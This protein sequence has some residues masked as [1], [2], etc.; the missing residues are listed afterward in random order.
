MEINNPSEL[1]NNYSEFK[2]DLENLKENENKK[3]YL[4]HKKDLDE[5]F[6]I[7]KNYENKSMNDLKKELSNKKIK[8][9]SK[10]SEIEDTELELVDKKFVTFLNDN[11][12]FLKN[13]ELILFKR[14]KEVQE[15]I[16]RHNKILKIKNKTILQFTESP[17]DLDN[18]IN[19]IKRS[20]KN[21]NKESE[22]LKNKQIN[23]NFISKNGNNITI[24]KLN[25]KSNT[26]IIKTY[27]Y[28]EFY[29]I[30]DRIIKRQN[31]II[32]SIKDPLN[33][34]TS[35]SYFILNRK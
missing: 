20:I 4:I 5:F 28:F 16:F 22:I 35:N 26:K 24:K 33:L 9:I 25:K 7:C 13:K 27:D 2:K 10:F 30:L 17:F 11:E 6:Q 19:N 18:S 32:Q 23:S 1:I 31:K 29:K 3:V 21:N 8:L 15:I 12:E 34:G 14:T